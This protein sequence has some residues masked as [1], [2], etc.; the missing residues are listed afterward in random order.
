[1]VRAANDLRNA[2]FLT[3]MSQKVSDPKTKAL[4][5]ELA[6]QLIFQALNNEAM[7]ESTNRIES[8]RRSAKG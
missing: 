8:R 2:L 1:M 5:S 3:R 4:L 6:G 7:A